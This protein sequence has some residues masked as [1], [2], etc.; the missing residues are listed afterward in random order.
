VQ[1]KTKKQN[2]LIPNWCQ[3]KKTLHV[4]NEQKHLIKFMMKQQLVA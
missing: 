1:N 3:K 2:N 4:S